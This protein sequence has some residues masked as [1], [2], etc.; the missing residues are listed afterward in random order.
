M[1]GWGGDTSDWKGSSSYK[2][3]SAKKPYLDKL[4]D[5]SAKSG[6]RSYSKP[7]KPDFKLVDPRGKEI[8]SE[9]TNPIIIGVDVTGSMNTWPAEIFD[10]LPL[11]YQT[12]SQY[13]DYV[14][15]CFAAIGDATC[16]EYPLQ[17]NSFG[18]GLDLEK[19][20]KALYPEG[21]GGGQISESYELFGYLIDKH[22]KTPKAT[23]PF[24]FIYGD[25][26]FYNKI[27][28]IHIEDLIG[29]KS[30]SDVDSTSM[31]KSLT[32]KY[33]L[34]F[35]HKPYG[36]GN[37]P[38]VDK[39]VINHWAKAIGSQRI[40]E[41]PSYDRAVDIAMGIVAK[42]WGQFSDFKKNLSA[43]QDSKAVKDS[44]YHSIRFVAD[45]KDT[46]SKTMKDKSS[47]KASLSKMF[48]DAK[49]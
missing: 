4:A 46:S 8:T 21:G 41:L 22:V 24:L 18:K 43:R 3:D 29:D 39:E 14:E 16:D 11:L 12:L 25:E 40:I 45:D 37:E 15:F 49:K 47:A 5:D 33:N 19:H 30:E 34:Y 23:S 7:K 9:S 2:F 6:P 44:A 26:K 32:Q 48:D 31:W 20:I 10:R 1:Y 35:L 27:N 36:G 28:K 38:S 13:R 42:Y 17:V